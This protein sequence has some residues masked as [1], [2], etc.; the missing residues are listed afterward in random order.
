MVAARLADA[1]AGRRAAELAAPDQQRLVPQARALQIGDQRRD[2]LIGLAGVQAVVGDAV[3]VAVPGVF[4]VAAAGIELHEADA[5]SQQPPR[6][7]ALAAE[8]GGER[9][10]RG[11]TSSASLASRG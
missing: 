9:V 1:F 2:R 11:R 5:R 7:Q 4:E 8:V 3:V 10:G 6:D